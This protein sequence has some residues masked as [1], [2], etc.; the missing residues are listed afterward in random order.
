[1]YST[2]TILTHC[3]VPV[4]CEIRGVQ[5]K[6]KKITILVMHTLHVLVEYI[7]EVC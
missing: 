4:Y 2:L 7:S 3:L 1:M 5:E 6:K